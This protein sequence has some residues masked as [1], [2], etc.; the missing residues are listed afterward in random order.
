MKTWTIRVMNIANEDKPPR[1][2]GASA[3]DTWC[4]RDGCAHVVTATTLAFAREIACGQHA[5][6][7]T[8]RDD[9]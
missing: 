9:R 4:Y 5:E 7:C 1:W 2:Y 8:T 3:G 6:Q